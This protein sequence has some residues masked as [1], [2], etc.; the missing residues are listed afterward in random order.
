[1]QTGQKTTT[2]QVMEIV[3]LYIALQALKQKQTAAWYAVLKNM[4]SLRPHFEKYSETEKEITERMAAKDEAGAVRYDENGQP[5][6][7][8]REQAVQFSE[9]LRT[10]QTA[11]VE[12]TLHPF[13][14][15]PEFIA[16]AHAPAVIEPI[17]NHLCNA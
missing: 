3:Q 4:Q 7:T 2:L 1:M 12:V 8:T 5:V 14:F 11:P 13:E 16:E 17:F 10:E 15:T 9:Y 6:F